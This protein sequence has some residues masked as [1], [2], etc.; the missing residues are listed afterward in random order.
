MSERDETPESDFECP[1]CGKQFNG[2]WSLHHHME[3]CQKALRLEGDDVDPQDQ[4][5]PWSGDD[6][7]GASS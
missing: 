4:D 1:G 3:R 5:D 2:P 7:M 6:M